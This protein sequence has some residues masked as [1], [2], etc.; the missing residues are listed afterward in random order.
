MRTHEDLPPG[1][2]ERPARQGSAGT[3][4][5]GAP[6]FRDLGRDA[7]EAIHGRRTTRYRIAA[8]SSAFMPT[9]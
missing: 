7:C 8:C 2:G 9:R 1:E 5:A 4:E 3:W 6:I